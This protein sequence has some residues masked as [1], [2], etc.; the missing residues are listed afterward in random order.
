MPSHRYLSSTSHGPDCHCMD[1]KTAS[2]QQ[3]L[4]NFRDDVRDEDQKYKQERAL[5]EVQKMLRNEF[6]RNNKRQAQAAKDKKDRDDL[7]KYREDEAAKKSAEA[8][9]QAI[10]RMM[11]AEQKDEDARRGRESRER[12]ERRK[13]RRDYTYEAYG[14]ELSVVKTPDL[15]GLQKR[16]IERRRSSSSAPKYRYRTSGAWY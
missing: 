13:N 11:E 16:T 10:K 8:A 7:K 3:T 15:F 2:V 9:A 1:C 12:E 6:D 5:H 4:Q 14:V